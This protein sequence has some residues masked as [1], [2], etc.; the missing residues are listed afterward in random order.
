MFVCRGTLG[1]TSRRSCTT[2][3]AATAA[4]SSSSSFSYASQLARSTVETMTSLAIGSFLNNFKGC[5]NQ[6]FDPS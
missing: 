4:S 6:N 3:S 5:G 2:A 1:D